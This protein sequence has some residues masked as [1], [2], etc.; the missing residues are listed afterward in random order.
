MATE[1]SVKRT[2]KRTSD[3]SGKPADALVTIKIGD[4]TFKLDAAKSELDGLLG[5]ARESRKRAPSA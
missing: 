3:L 5:V 1:I 2:V 4:K